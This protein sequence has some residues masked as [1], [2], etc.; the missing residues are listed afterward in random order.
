MRDMRSIE[1]RLR[2]VGRALVRFGDLKPPQRAVAAAARSAM[3]SGGKRVRPAVCMAA[4]RIAAGGGERP[5]WSV[6]IDAAAAM[7]MLH[8]AS[9]VLDDLPCMDDASTRRG[10]PCTHVAFGEATAILCATT[11]VAAA[12]EVV[13]RSS[14]RRRRRVRPRK[15]RKPRKPRMPRKHRKP[16]K[17]RPKRYRTR[18]RTRRASASARGDAEADVRVAVLDALL[19]A[20]ERMSNGQ[21]MDLF[22]GATARAPITREAVEAVHAGKTGALL[23]AAAAAGALAAGAPDAAAPQGWA[24]VYGR[25]LGLAF[26]VADDVLDATQSDAATGKTSGRDIPCGKPSYVAAAG[27]GDSVAHVRRLV[28]SAKRAL[29]PGPR[30]GRLRRIA[31][32]LCDSAQRAAASPRPV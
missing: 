24:R 6:A 12:L 22:F 3:L 11:M 32:A 20:A 23:E 31:D 19:E 10:R 2:N 9:L 1:R 8:A 21:M 25:A 28:E 18:R 16:R 26:Q 27:L 4:F 14:Y 30:T 17:R 15:P 7:E 13:A 29:P 5:R